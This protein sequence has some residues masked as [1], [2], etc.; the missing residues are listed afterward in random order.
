M[1]GM[2]LILVCPASMCG[3]NCSAGAELNAYLTLVMEGVG[4]WVDD[5]DDQAFILRVRRQ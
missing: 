1:S 5:T 2:V 3:S 4:V